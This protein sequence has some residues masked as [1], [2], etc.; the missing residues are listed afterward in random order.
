MHMMDPT[1]IYIYPTSKRCFGF[2]V[3][4]SS[5]WTYRGIFNLKELRSPSLYCD[6]SYAIYVLT[7]MCAS[8]AP[9]KCVVMYGKQNAMIISWDIMY[10][11]LC[12]KASYQ[13]WSKTCDA[14]CD[15]ILWTS[16]NL[17]LKR[18]IFHDIHRHTLCNN[19]KN[20]QCCRELCDE[21]FGEWCHEAMHCAEFIFIL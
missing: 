17:A 10:L 16:L 18:S 15:D 8:C 9:H 20:D 11:M 13:S 2:Q 6:T 5:S 14:P 3:M 12:Y 1:G 21:A 4:L 7:I 19:I